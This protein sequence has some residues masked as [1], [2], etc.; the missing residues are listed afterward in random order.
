MN[1][2]MRNEKLRSVFEHLGFS[3]V[4]TVISSG[5]VLF[6]THATDHKILEHMIERALPEQLGFTSTTIVLAQEEL[7]DIAAHNPFKGREH[8]SK[9]YLTV[10][11]GKEEFKAPFETPYVIKEKGSSI[12]RIYGRSVFSLV[13]L[14]GKTPDLMTWLEKTFSKQIT[15]RTWKTVGRIIEKLGKM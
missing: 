3:K 5:N 10:T 7:K 2:N 11:F 15:T 1:P 9:T 12:L 6:E 13:E 8:S 14:T 4:Q